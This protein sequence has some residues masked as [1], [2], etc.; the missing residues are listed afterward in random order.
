MEHIA[1]GL[2]EETTYHVLSYVGK[3]TVH[4]A[5]IWRRAMRN[6]FGSCL[7]WLPNGVRPHMEQ[8]AALV[9][10]AFTIGLLGGETLRDMLYG[11]S[12]TS[13]TPAPATESAES[14][15]CRSYGA[16]PVSS[17]FS[18]ARILCRTNSGANSITKSCSRLFDSSNRHPPDLRPKLSQ[19]DRKPP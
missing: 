11:G 5:G 3:G 14:K 6:R 12:A 18:S 4:V 9:L 17:S 1:E 16:V 13:G 15:A 8:M 10:L 2:A 19:N 7:A